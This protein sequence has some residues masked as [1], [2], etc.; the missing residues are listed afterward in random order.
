MNPLIKLMCVYV[1]LA[2]TVAC[3]QIHTSVGSF[4]SPLWQ[5]LGSI[6]SHDSR[7]KIYER[8]K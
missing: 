3:C 8:G 6:L 1:A 4:L 5:S 7:T 2:A